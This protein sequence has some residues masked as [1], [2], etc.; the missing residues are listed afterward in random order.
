MPT[1]HLSLPESTY[2][3]LKQRAAELGVQVTDVIKFYIKLGLEKGFTPRGDQG[4]TEKMLHALSNKVD[5][6]EREFRRKTVRLEGRYKELEE[7]I[8]FLIER[9]DMLEETIAE[10]KARTRAHGA[11]LEE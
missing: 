5:R 2:R 4:E 10:M 11:A 8:Y 7:T 9:I 6:L 3:E 1:V